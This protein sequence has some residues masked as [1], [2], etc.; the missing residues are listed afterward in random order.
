MRR[1][2]ECAFV[3]QRENLYT[4]HMKKNV[5]GD[6]RHGAKTNGAGLAE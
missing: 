5:G 1:N 6:V 4:V 3:E 2:R